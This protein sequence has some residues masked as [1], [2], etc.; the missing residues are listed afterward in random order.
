MIQRVFAGILIVI[1]ALGILTASIFRSASP[2]TYAFTLPSDEETNG[3]VMG[4]SEEPKEIEYS[5]V[6]PGKILPDSPLWSLK[7]LRDK[8]WIFLTRDLTKRSELKLLCADKRVVASRMLFEKDKPEMALSTLTKAEKY[9]ED[10]VAD[11]EMSRG[12][13]GDTSNLLLRLSAASLKH[14]EVMEQILELA[15]SDAK[16][17]IIKTRGY[18]EK[19][20]EKS[21]QGLNEKGMLAPEN[22]FEGEN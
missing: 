19:A 14:I 16:P 11:E 9:L 6:Y 18:A 12:K 20:F 17:E 13:G 10:A 21:K 15:P 2:S 22:P 1:F 3:E 8:I 5:F 4:E 7:A